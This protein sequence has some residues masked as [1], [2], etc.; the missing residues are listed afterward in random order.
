MIEFWQRVRDLLKDNDIKQ[1]E[2]AD[3]LDMS[4]NSFS[5][6]IRNDTLPNASK[7]YQI[8]KALGVSV[9]YLVTGIGNS[10]ASTNGKFFVPLLSQKLSAGKGAFVPE[11]DEPKAF[12]EA[13]KNLAK[14]GKNIAAL[15]I[16]GDSMEPTF[17]SGDLILCD[18]LGYHGEGIYAIRLNGN[19][20]VKRIA[21]KPKKIVI[22]SDN[23]KY[24]AFEEP[25][26]SE[27]LSIIGRVHY[28]IKHVD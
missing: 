11:T 20:Y 8:A 4:S 15:E 21:E 5:Q 17:S 19:G 25:L 1:Y 14:Y 7:T 9:E 16:A 26:G 6:W 18:S 13:P 10:A 24:D 12:V 2:L 3:L 22:K 23:P 27:A 28:V